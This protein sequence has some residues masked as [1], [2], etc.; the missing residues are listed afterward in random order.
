MWNIW[1]YSLLAY[2]VEANFFKN[3]VS[4]QKGDMIMQYIK[5]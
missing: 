5:P 1:T 2:V 4:Y 3:L